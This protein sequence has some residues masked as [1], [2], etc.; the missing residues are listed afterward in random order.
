M[1]SLLKYKLEKLDKF[2]YSNNFN[3]EILKKHR[4]K[5]NQIFKGV[6]NSGYVPIDTENITF[7]R[8]RIWEENRPWNCLEEMWFPPSHLLRPGKLNDPYQRLLYSSIDENTA[9]MEKSPPEGGFATILSFKVK[10]KKIICLELGLN[11]IKDDQRNFHNKKDE[12]LHKYITKKCKMRVPDEKPWYYIPTIIY[13]NSFKTANFDAFVYDSVAAKFTGENFAFN[14]E[15]IKE[16]LI[17]ESARNVKISNKKGK[18]DFDV[19]CIS[20]SSKIENGEFIYEN[21]EDCQGHNITSKMEL[22]KSNQ[23]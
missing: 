16:N 20:L 4:K 22:E 1:S 9:L 15:F 7:H 3:M 21:I 6:R 14:P 19:T 10:T 13:A 11:S 17:F 18:D 2:L 8:A 5:F 12:Y 23:K